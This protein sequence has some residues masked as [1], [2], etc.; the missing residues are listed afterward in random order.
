MPLPFRQV[1]GDPKPIAQEKLRSE[2]SL[3][4][5]LIGT[6]KPFELEERL[7]EGRMQTVHKGIPPSARHFWLGCS[8]AYAKRTYLVYQDERYTYGQMYLQTVRAAHWLRDRFQVRKG[9]KGEKC[10]GGGPAARR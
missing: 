2:E 1:F 7:I 5:A 6:G 8:Q 9:D 10:R 4:S 3:R